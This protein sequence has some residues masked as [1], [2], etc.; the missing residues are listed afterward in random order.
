M[1][2]EKEISIILKSRRP[3]TDMLNVIE[4]LGYNADQFQQAFDIA[5]E[6]DN[7]SLVKLLYSNF[8][9]GKVIVEFTLLGKT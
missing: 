5:L 2:F 9:A 3:D 6:M 1:K 7:R 8:N 4:V